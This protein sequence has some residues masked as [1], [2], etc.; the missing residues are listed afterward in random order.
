MSTTTVESKRTFTPEALLAMEDAV[1]YELV[2]GEL[3]ERNMGFQSSRVG[4]RVGQLLANYCDDHVPGWVAGA[5][6]GFQC[7]PDDP[8][9][10][11]KPDVSLV[12][13]HSLPADEEPTGHCRVAPDLAVEVVLPNDRYADVEAKVDDYLSAGT[14]LVWIVNPQNRSVRV[15][16]A[17]GTTREVSEND[18]LEGETVVPG[19][20]CKVSEFFRT[21]APAETK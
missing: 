18:E 6:A 20:R 8:G 13:L 11:R 2:D 16:R 3:V 21:P 1:N 12:S 7:F 5:D 15:H 19:F 17:D 10:V 4:F 9:K 14:K